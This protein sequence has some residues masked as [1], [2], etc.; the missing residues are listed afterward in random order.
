MNKDIS[1]TNLSYIVLDFD[2][3]IADTSSHWLSAKR[4]FLRG[5]G[6][7]KGEAIKIA[8][9]FSGRNLKDF[10]TFS[11]RRAGI[12]DYDIDVLE[13]EIDSDR[14]FIENINEVSGSTDFITFC[15][16]SGIRLMICTNSPPTYVELYLTKLGIR[17]CIDQVF[18][19]YNHCAPKPSP[20]IYTEIAN[21][22]A[23][24]DGT[25]L[26]TIE[27]S[28]SGVSSA[29][30]A[31]IECIWIGR[32]DELKIYDNVIYASNFSVLRMLLSERLDRAIAA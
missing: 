13:S 3:T 26:F 20:E 15:H 4:K 8:G 10:I 1:T 27:D 11:C 14:N 17:H 5:L 6:Y 24:T 31:G 23:E 9:N 22:L 21:H 18:S 12:T 30:K 25:L 29:I 32:E 19:T 7:R 28:E 16:R 2:G